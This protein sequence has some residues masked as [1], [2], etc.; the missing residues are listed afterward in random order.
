MVAD[1]VAGWRA[2]IETALSTD[3]ADACRTVA[4]GMDPAAGYA[5]AFSLLREA[6]TP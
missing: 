1:D 3:V 4:A 6:A 2:G 5:R